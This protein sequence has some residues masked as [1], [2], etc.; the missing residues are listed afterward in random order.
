MWKNTVQPER[1]QMKI[2]LMRIASWI[3]NTTNTH[4]EYV[5]LVV[6]HCNSGCKN[7]PQYYV[8]LK[9]PAVIQPY[10]IIFEG[11]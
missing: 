8:T 7:A 1:L 6:F 10:G 9:L 3:L 11:C 5:I 2:W 4:S